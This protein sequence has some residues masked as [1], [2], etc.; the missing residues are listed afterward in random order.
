MEIKTVKMID[1]QEWD[2]LVRTTYHR[3]YSFQQQEGCKSRGH[4]KFSVPDTYTEND[5]FHDSIPDIVNGS[6]MGVKF[7]VWLSRKP[8]ENTF[9]TDWENRLF[10]HRNFYPDF[11]TVVNDL[12]KKGLIEEGSYTIDIDW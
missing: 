10:W 3:P 4:F 12:Y 1:V 9:K 7:D 5:E 8:D 11:Y 6:K 2:N